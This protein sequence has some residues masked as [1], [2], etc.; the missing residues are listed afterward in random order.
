[1]IDNQ[2]SEELTLSFK[3]DFRVTSFYSK[4]FLESSNGD[5]VFSKL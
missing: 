2:E 4:T 3:I 1:M 5:E